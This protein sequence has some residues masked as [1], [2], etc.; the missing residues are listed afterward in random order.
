MQ[1]RKHKFGQTVALLA[2]G[3]G[4][5]MLSACGGGSEGGD[6]VAALDEKLVGKGSDPAMTGAVQDK[7]LVD[8]DLAGKSNANMVR[9]GDSPFDGKKPS[10]SGYEG[11]TASAEELA[12]A[13]LMRAPKP[14]VV[15]AEECNDCA[16]NRGETLEARAA[17]QGVKRGK[18]TC[19]AKLQYGAGWA[20]R[21]PTEFPVYPNG[22]VKE[23]A[24]VEGGICDIRV[25]SFTTGA[26]RQA[27]VDYYYTRAKRSGFTADYEIRDGEHML[28]GVRDNDGGAYV[29]TLTALKGGG[30]A[31]DIVANNGR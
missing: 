24:G 7:I 20:A 27:V 19:E 23:A 28:G 21:M 1:I 13:K 9:A 26:A 12:N 22:R 8:P 31:V 17:A 4:I 14:R 5:L 15:G 10:D 25:V 16:A 29:I 6:D 18:G 3:G 11:A 30:T 2:L